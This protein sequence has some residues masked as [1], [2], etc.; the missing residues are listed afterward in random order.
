MDTRHVQ[1]KYQLERILNFGL[2]RK[3]LQNIRAGTLNLIN[4][5]KQK[6]FTGV[7]D[8]QGKSKMKK[9]FI[10]FIIVVVI[11]IDSCSNKMTPAGSGDTRNTGFDSAAYD[12][13]YVEAIK[14]KM[15]G[16][17]GDA[18]KYFEQCLKINPKS[19]ASYYQ[20]AQIIA[21]TG[22]LNNAKKYALKAADLDKANFWYIMLVSQLYY[23]SKN[24]DSAILWNEKAGKIFPDNENIQLALGNL[25]IE[26]KNYSKANS[27]F[28]SFDRKYGVNETSTLLS[29]RSLV[30]TGNFSAAK[31]KAEELLSQKP[32]DVMYN[33][34][35]AEV[36]SD[37]NENEKALEIYNKLIKSNPTD[38][39]VQLSMAD[40]LLKQKNYKDLFG[41][42]NTIVLN[43]AIRKEDKFQ[44]F[45]G[46]IEN[47]DLVADTD[48][49][50]SVALMILEA[51]YKDDDNIPLLRTD[52]MVKQGKP[53]E[54]AIRLEEII[55]ERPVDYNAWIKLLLVYADMKNW[56]K[57]A[58]MG[59]QCASLF[60]MSLAAKL[61]YAN[62]AL[63]TGKYDTA[64]EELRKAEILAGNEK[65]FISQVLTMRADVYYRQKNY[66]KAFE[67][68]E[69]AL[70]NDHTDVTV[71]N[72]YAYYLAEQNMKLKEAE[73]LAKKVVETEKGNTTFL[74]TYGWVLYK[75][76]KINEAARIFE[77]IIKNSTVP[78]AEWYEHYGYILKKQNKCQK[79]VEYWRKAIEIDDRKT[80]LKG[81][82]EN[83]AR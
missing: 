53:G 38:P 57:L 41:L 13:V 25:Y 4:I 51:S 45:T 60:N 33:G 16:N 58:E 59:A 12:R 77:S 78:D 64:L 67:T 79:A 56:E 30:A 70:K 15:M 75:R 80:N 39:N 43:D 83:C 3:K 5:L 69:E 17:A 1:Q 19:D 36:L 11:V 10:S 72:N 50:L 32:D 62:G 44:L 29:I 27:I 68:F 54:A 63:E 71:M 74:D 48:N 21:N 6:V 34:L 20:M 8:I 22:D 76:G 49:R 28:D 37:A 61:L 23:Q 7:L 81:E 46:L 65:D 42:L 66:D 52:L 73:E 40:F 18:L 35:Y 31:A 9:I 47:Q 82:I 24:L 14:Q 55:K 2:M 26:N